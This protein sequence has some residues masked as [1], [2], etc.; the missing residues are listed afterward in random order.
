ML[1]AKWTYNFGLTCHF[2][3]NPFIPTLWTSSMTTS[4]LFNWLQMLSKT[5]LAIRYVFLR[6]SRV[7][8]FFSVINLYNRGILI[9]FFLTRIYI[10][11]ALLIYWALWIYT[12]WIENAKNAYFIS[13]EL[14]YSQYHDYYHYNDHRFH[15]NLIIKYLLFR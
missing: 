6:R 11:E 10:W 1:S 13:L 8:A 9:L 3:L 14:W 2:R 12:K 4:R 15:H 5:K 7:I